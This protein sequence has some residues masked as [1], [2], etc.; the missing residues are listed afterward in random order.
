MKNPGTKTKMA[1]RLDPGEREVP[2]S[3]VKLRS[4]R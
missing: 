1:G 2:V 4:C 3:G